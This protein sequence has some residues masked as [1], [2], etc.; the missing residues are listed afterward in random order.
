MMTEMDIQM[1]LKLPNGT[2]PGMHEF[3]PTSGA[4][5]RK[6]GGRNAR[7]H[8]GKD[9]TRSVFGPIRQEITLRFILY[10]VVIFSIEAILMSILL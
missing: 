6:A 1:L 5:S 7:N 10:T 3:R 4:N 9:S 2:I 8:A